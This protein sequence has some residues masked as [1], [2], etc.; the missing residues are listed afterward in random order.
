[1]TDADLI[2]TYVNLLIIEY[3][4]PN[5]QPKALATIAL[6]AGQ[7]IANQIIGQVGAAYSITT[8]YG[9]VLAQGAQLNVLGQ[10]VGAERILVGYPPSPF[11]FFGFEDTRSAYDP[12]IG[13]FGDTT[14]G[15]P[16]DYYEDTRNQNSGIYTQTDEQMVQLINYLAA[17]NNAYFSIQ[18]IDDILY[19]FFGSYV[20]V[21]ETATMQITY[22]Q[23]VS[24]PGTL[25]GIV[26]FIGALPHPAGVEVID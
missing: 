21:A 7:A 12:S 23:S 10:F 9:Q 14:V 25:Y 24:D 16:A 20:T 8:L 3:S 6:V 11:T 18:E 26:K 17:A 4:D 5:N 1:M 15:V 19:A 13:G 22:T 2:Q